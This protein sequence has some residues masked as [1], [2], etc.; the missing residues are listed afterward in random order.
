MPADSAAD[1][2][3]GRACSPGQ[4]AMWTEAVLWPNA[5]RRH[6]PRATAGLRLRQFPPAWFR[7]IRNRIGQ[8]T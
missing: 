8:A 5:I 7:E 4:L 3:P 6:Q 2:I 1:K